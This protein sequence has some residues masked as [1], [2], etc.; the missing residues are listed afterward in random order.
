[1]HSHHSRTATW[2][3]ALLAM[4]SLG[5]YR[6]AAQEAT[7]P[8]TPA[9][10]Q[11]EVLSRGPVHEAFAE[12]VPMELQAGLIA[13]QQ[14]PPNIEELPPTEKPKGQQFVWIPGYWAWDAD[15][16][17]YIWVSACWRVPP[18]K[19]SWV[20]GYWA[21]VSG[22]WQWIAGF[23]TPANI[24]DIQYLPAPPPV[25]DIEPVGS[26]PSV[27]M[28]WVPPCMYWSQGLYVRR[29]GYWLDAQ[30]NWV[31]VPSHYVS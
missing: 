19:M 27:D 29:S 30:S 4:A 16:N 22:G 9:E 14:P 2:A 7:P 6:L 1:M 18:P 23:W 17:G 26:P 25:G 20:P 5:S 11:P 31:W 8:A 21:Q 28:I 15:R 3:I 12:P 10:E 13:P 24:R